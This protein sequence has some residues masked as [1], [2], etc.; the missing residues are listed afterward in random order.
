[1]ETVK[2]VKAVAEHHRKLLRDA[3]ERLVEIDPEPK[4]QDYWVAWI[5]NYGRSSWHYHMPRIRSHDQFN[6]ALSAFKLLAGST[7]N[8]QFKDG[9][10]ALGVEIARAVTQFGT[11][12]SVP[13]K[14]S[15][16]YATLGKSRLEKL[17]A[18]LKRLKKQ[19]GNYLR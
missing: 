19:A 18:E 4:H 7:V 12:P 16:S 15:Y 2:E 14:V 6:A 5:Q 13:I 1:M 9:A 3:E 11:A 10:N 8:E 17:T